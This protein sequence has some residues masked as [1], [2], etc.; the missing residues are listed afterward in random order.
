M[1]VYVEEDE[2]QGADPHAGL[3]RGGGEGDAQPPAARAVPAHAP[4]RRAQTAWR[5]RGAAT[6]NAGIRQ[7]DGCSRTTIFGAQVTK[8]ISR[9]RKK[10]YP[11][12]FWFWEM[13]FDMWQIN[14]YQIFVLNRRYLNLT[15][16]SDA[17]GAI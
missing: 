16:F 12:R 9:L 11:I 15:L 14:T 6:A 3:E 10:H 7:R 4:Q 13:N 1:A 5:V 17:D 8:N 2:L